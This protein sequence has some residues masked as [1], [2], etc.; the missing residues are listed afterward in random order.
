MSGT[1]ACSLERDWGLKTSF[2]CRGIVV[3]I[4]VSGGNT[5]PL[6]A[7]HQGRGGGGQG[8]SERRELQG[9]ESPASRNAVLHV[10]HPI[11]K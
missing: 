4:D 2:L 6:E 9:P 8:E 10:T 5:A 1:D 7:K 11:Y 3:L